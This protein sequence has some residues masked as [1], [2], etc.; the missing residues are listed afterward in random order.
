MQPTPEEYKQRPTC[1]NAPECE[2]GDVIGLGGRGAFGYGLI[3][4]H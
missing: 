4:F 2:C 1:D 3:S